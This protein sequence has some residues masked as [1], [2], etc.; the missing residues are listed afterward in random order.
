MRLL[1]LVCLCFLAHV[2]AKEPPLKGETTRVGK[3]GKK[4]AECQFGKEFREIGSSWYLDLGPPFGV[5]YCMKCECLP[6]RKKRRILGRVHCRNIKH[7]CPVPTCEE[8]ILPPGRCCKV[9]PENL[10]STPDIVQDAAPSEEDERSLKYFAALLTGRTSQILDRDELTNYKRFQQE[11]V[12]TGRFVFHRR[13]LYYSFYSTSRPRGIQFLDLQGN[14]LEEHVIPANTSY[15]NATGKICGVWKRVPRDYRK[16]MREEKMVVSLLWDRPELTLGG[17]LFRY[18]ALSSE[19][20]SALLEGGDEGA[21]GSAIIS[22]ASSA[23]SIHITL[24]FNGVFTPE[25]VAD[26]PLNLK[27]VNPEKGHIVIDEIIKIEKPSNELNTIEFS[28]VVTANDLKLLSKQKLTVILSS[29][30]S[31]LKLA[32]PI[33]TRVACQL[34]QSTLSYQS[35]LDSGNSIHDYPVTLASG[36]SWMFVDKEGFLQYTVQLHGIDEV[37]VVTL[38]SVASKKFMELEDLTPTLKNGWANGTLDRLSPKYLEQLYA[39]DLGINVGTPNNPSLIRGK[40]VPRIVAEARNAPAPI[41]LMRPNV[42]TY[43]NNTGLIWAFFDADCNLHYEVMITG[44]VSAD[45]SL[46]LFIEDIPFIA[47]GAPVTRKLLEE[48]VGLNMEGTTVGLSQDELLRLEAGVVYF[49]IRSSKTGATILKGH[50]KQVSVPSSCLPHF[51]DNDVPTI[52]FNSDPSNGNIIEGSGACYHGSRFHDD[53]SQWTSTV[54]HC[55]MC[56]CVH[57]RVRCDPILCP[58]V[59]CSSPTMQDGECCPSCGNNIQEISAG[60][61]RGCHLGDQLFPPGARWH[62]YLPPNGFD[63]CAI[64]SCNATTL[65]VRCPRVECPPL[66]CEEKAA[67]RPDKKA[68]CKVCPTNLSTTKSPILSEAASEEKMPQQRLDTD[69]IAAGGCKYPVG[70]PY[71]N[72]AE[73]HPRVYSHGEVKCVKCR[74]K[75]GKVKCER[76]RCGRWSCNDECC[77]SKCQKRRRRESKIREA[78]LRSSRRNLSQF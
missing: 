4:R 34:M 1:K 68:C 13:S 69:V 40:L 63:S 52:N 42:S 45:E 77:A 19:L 72:G 15:Q 70:G 3:P 73:W 53:G 48:F 20:Y 64:C 41:F 54:D 6:D 30:H 78:R 11:S 62:P 38:G 21:G 47:P 37:A 55:T 28:S 44:Q 5:M 17:Q 33:V 43:A 24:L 58:P 59:Q 32:G 66:V 23:P 65:E 26:V 9:C 57:S 51:S 7:E 76:K 18:R 50:W 10:I 36:L 56:N 49:D 27:I 16:L 31:E 46:Q 35:D 39:G 22:V 71:E 14:I 29:K 67:I 25:D 74:C 60:A 2:F 12:A 8:P 75:D 61:S